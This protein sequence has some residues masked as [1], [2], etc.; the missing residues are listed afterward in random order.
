MSFERQP[1]RFYFE[2]YR[3]DGKWAI[4][5]F[6]FKDDIGDWASEKAKED[7]VHPQFDK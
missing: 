2:F 6:G 7:Y 4:Y 1:F 3:S 5:N